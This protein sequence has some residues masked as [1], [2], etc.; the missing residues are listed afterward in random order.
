[1]DFKTKTKT[2]KIKMKILKL[3]LLS[4]TLLSTVTLL[5]QTVEPQT[6]E[7]VKT[8]GTKP[9]DEGVK[10]VHQED[11]IKGS[12]DA[13]NSYEYKELSFKT[14]KSSVYI[15]RDK[16]S[17]APFKCLHYDGKTKKITTIKEE[18][19]NINSINFQV[20]TS[21]LKVGDRILIINNKELKSQYAVQ[22]KTVI[23]EVEII[24]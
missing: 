6:I 3:L 9:V 16:L 5:A 11:T 21:I 13:N 2:R 15:K 20:D 18:Q 19:V 10:L 24:E 4:T 8:T 1:V 12:T 23:V 7:K 22:G 14:M 17:H